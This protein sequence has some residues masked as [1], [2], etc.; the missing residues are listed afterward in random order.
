MLPDS[1]ASVASRSLPE[2]AVPVLLHQM[3]L[4]QLNYKPRM[5]QPLSRIYC[6]DFRSIRV[7]LLQA[8]TT[9]HP[10]VNLSNHLLIFVAHP[11]TVP[12]R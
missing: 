4:A 5:R 10:P 8:Y 6:P 1:V 7:Y 11:V 3:A 9:S 12:L 2:Q